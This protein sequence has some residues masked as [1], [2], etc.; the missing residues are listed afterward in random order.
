MSEHVPT[1][2]DV[3]DVY[4]WDDAYG[5]GIDY[6]KAAKFDRW[7]AEYTRA[8]KAGAWD[9]GFD[10]GERDVMQHKTWDE[11]CIEPC[12]ENPYRKEQS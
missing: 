12:I 4:A 2:E 5:G 11:P 8:M 6:E 3:R 9:E 7:L 1:T 10:A